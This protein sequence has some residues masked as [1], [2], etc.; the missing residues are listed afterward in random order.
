M[1][2]YL[3]VFYF[4]SDVMFC[5]VLFALTGKKVHFILVFPET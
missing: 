3:P 1:V 4:L 5:F 2:T